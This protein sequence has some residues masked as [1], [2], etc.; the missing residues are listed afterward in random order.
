M[1]FYTRKQLMLESI[2]IIIF[3]SMIFTALYFYGSLPEKIP[4]H[5]NAAGEAD[6][7][8]SRNSI[9]IFPI[10]YMII[11][12]ILLFLPTIDVYRENVKK[13]FKNYFGIRL[14]MGLF[15]LAM[16]IITLLINYYD[17]NLSKAIILAID[18]LFIAIGYF[19]KDIKRNYFAGIRT[20]WALSDEKIWDETHKM[21]GKL[22]MITGG[23]LLIVSIVV[24]AMVSF[25]ITI[26]LLILISL[27]SATYSYRVYKRYNGKIYKK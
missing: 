7:F 1:A 26:S 4:I 27:F 6:G 9:L 14:T 3:A 11:Y 25:Y 20:P 15:F 22:F 19:I 10:M 24:N 21:S 8:G 13:S 2:H 18:L 17:F 16:F 12:F 5:W 23:L